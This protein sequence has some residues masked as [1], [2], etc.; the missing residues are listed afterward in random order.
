MQGTF[1][2]GESQS[3]NHGRQDSQRGGKEESRPGALAGT[4]VR[5][6]GTGAD[7]PVHQLAGGAQEGG[8]GKRAGSVPLDKDIQGA[9]G[10]LD[11]EASALRQRG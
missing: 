1:P 4:G 2:I 6:G 11:N 8:A 10:M 9:G 3:A 5:T 7:P